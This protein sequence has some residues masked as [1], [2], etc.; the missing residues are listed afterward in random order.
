MNWLV[1]PI[2]SGQSFVTGLALLVVAAFASTRTKP[3]FRRVTVL[4]FLIGAIAVVV[5]STAI[6][7]WYYAVAV[8]VTM[9][10]ITSRFKNE[11]RRQSAFAM[12]GAWLIAALIEL[13][14]H[15]TDSLEPAQTRT[16]TVIGDSVTAGVDGDGACIAGAVRAVKGGRVMNESSVAEYDY[17]LTRLPGDQ[18]WSLRL[19]Q[20]G[21]DM[22]GDVYQEHDEALSVG[23]V[24][25]CRE[26]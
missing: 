2:V 11:W 21:L 25:L 19:L 8:T 22:G 14:H 26:S 18:G 24:W 4:S 3:I 1:Y 7:Y 17:T 16:M 10:W 12:A 23:T 15:I 9:V 5:S 13:P 6:P 20:D